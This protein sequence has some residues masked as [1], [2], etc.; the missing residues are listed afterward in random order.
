MPRTN[1]SSAQALRSALLIAASVIAFGPLPA[2]SGDPDAVPQN[3]LAT[4]EPD[5]DDLLRSETP[6]EEDVG[7]TQR[8]EI[9]KHL[10]VHV[11][12]RGSSANV[13]DKSSRDLLPLAQLSREKRKRVDAVL[14]SQSLFRRLPTV[15]VAVDPLAYAFFAAHPDVA[16][17]I[18]R[19]MKISKFELLQ[20][21]PFHYEADG[22]D[23][24]V[25]TVEMMYQ[26]PNNYLILCEG[27][28]KSPVLAKPIRAT[29]LMHLQSRFS[30]DKAGRT[31]VTHHADVFVS[32]P[33]QTVET[34][35]KLI[36]P[37][38]NLIAD[39]NFK[40]VSLF[41]NM[42]SLA[43]STQPGWVE[44]VATRL[45]GV[46]HIRKEQLLKLTA[47]IYVTARKQRLAK[48]PGAADASADAIVN[49]LRKGNASPNGPFALPFTRDTAAG[50]P[51]AATRI[52][53]SRNR[54]GSG[55]AVPANAPMGQ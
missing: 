44:Q 8:S 6:D 41:L 37:I 10:K 7:R 38:S 31:Y 24:S 53:N 20:T 39:R 26:G 27:A 40:E 52:A 12:A 29:S 49:P 13:I 15:T 45:D 1:F 50:S 16:V 17:A 36:S 47:H 9:A 55:I 32:F 35:A 46:P 23:G 22:G 21:G 3:R 28:Y 30:R 14:Q 42:M 18:W 33:S 54:G 19:V 2:L 51:D 48:Q 11:V 5:D 34:A 4:A 43:M 25:G